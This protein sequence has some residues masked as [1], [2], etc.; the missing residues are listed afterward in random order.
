MTQTPVRS[1]AYSRARRT[2]LRSW[3]TLAV[4]V[5]A[6]AREILGPLR[7]LVVAN[8]LDWG[9]D[10]GRTEDIELALSE[11]VTNALLHSGGPA[12]VKVKMRYGAVHLEVSDTSTL[13]AHPADATLDGECGRG[14]HLVKAFAY[15][16]SMQIHTWGKTIAA[17]F[18]AGFQRT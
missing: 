8:L 18:D 15:A 4:P 16:T 10:P 3:R 13:P 17:S 7:K 5:P 9:V 14:L 6:D 1:A 11:L 2:V 12:L